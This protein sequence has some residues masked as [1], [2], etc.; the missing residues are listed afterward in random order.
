MVGLQHAWNETVSTVTDYVTIRIS[1]VAQRLDVPAALL[2][3][4]LDIALFAFLG[5]CICF[6]CCQTT[7][8]S[9]ERRRKLRITRRGGETQRSRLTTPST[10]GVEAPTTTTQEPTATHD[11]MQELERAAK[12][13]Q[14]A[15]ARRLARERAAWAERQARQARRQRQEQRIEQQLQEDDGFQAHMRRWG[16]DV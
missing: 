14:R 11:A 2:E 9:P 7:K 12:K 6:V 1:N 10:D 5:L 4:I 8:G 16:H 15:R 3:N 13:E